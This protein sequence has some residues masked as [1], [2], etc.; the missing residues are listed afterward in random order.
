MNIKEAADRLG[1]TPRA[2]RFYEKKGL[3]SPAKQESNRYR[4]FSDQDIWRLQTIVS[5]REAGMSLSDIKLA[6]EKWEVDGMGELQYYLELQRSILMSE[7]LQL[8][9]ILDMTDRMIG[10]LKDE[11]GLPIEHIFGLAA[12]S[13]RLREQRGNW[14][15]RWNFNRL[16]PTH[17]E[18]VAAG[19]GNYADYAEALEKIVRLVVPAKGERGLDIGTGTGNLAGKFLERG[20]VMSGVDQSREMLRLCQTKHPGM[21]TRL[22]NFLALPYLR[23]QFDFVVSSF[24]FHHLSGDQQRL[25]LEEMDRVLK[26]SGRVAIADLMVPAADD[27]AHAGF[28]SASSLVRWFLEHGYTA[29]LRRLN[30]RLHILYARKEE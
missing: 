14:Q 3:L 19:S 10:L 26:P 7:W 9:Q 1:I 15:D 12:A 13:K 18:R 17:D 30:E 11:R 4:S 23:E 20:C 8:R 28:P 29:E 2:I 5:L 22:G 21:E 25:A 16:A 24:A 6:L 27:E